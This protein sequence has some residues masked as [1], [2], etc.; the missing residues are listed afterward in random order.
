MQN[1]QIA[2]IFN[3]VA[4]LLEIQGANSFRVRA[5]RN[6]ARTLENLSESVADLLA[7]PGRGLDSL[8]GIGKDLAGKIAV[9]VDTGQLPQ[10][11]ELRQQVPKGVVDMLRI[12]KELTVLDVQAGESSPIPECQRK[13]DALW[14]RA[15]LWFQDDEPVIAPSSDDRKATAIETWTP[16][17][18]AIEADIRDQLIGELATPRYGF[19][20][21]GLIKVEAKDE[22]CSTYRRAPYSLNK[23][24]EVTINTIV[25]HHSIGEQIHWV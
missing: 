20:P 7:T 12:H 23:I 15:R 9:I 24:E 5:Y 10:L 18:P 8:D 22:R 14:W 6:G 21:A 16:Q 4:D 13:R 25:H 1:Q 2:T 11:E 17:S 19:T 3:E